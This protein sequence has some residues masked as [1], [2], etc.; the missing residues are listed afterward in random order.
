MDEEVVKLI[1]G[2]LLHDIGKVI[3]RQGQVH[4]RHSEIGYEFLK[5]NLKYRD[6]EIMESVRYH[7]GNELSKAKIDD[8]SMAY[9]TYI[10]DNIAAA[11][12]RRNRDE[13]EFGYDKA[14]PLEPVFN[15][16]NGNKAKMYFEK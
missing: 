5:N 2:A 11:A 1:I 16:L 14:T 6:K 12:D 13:A 4:G 9:I 7:H 3:Y 15:I 10:A 8:N